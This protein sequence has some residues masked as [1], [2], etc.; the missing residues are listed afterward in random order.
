MDFYMPF[1]IN[2]EKYDSEVSLNNRA[3]FYS[4]ELSLNDW[5]IKQT[6]LLAILGHTVAQQHLI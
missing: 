2:N 6:D 5:V 3:D 1:L 4:Y